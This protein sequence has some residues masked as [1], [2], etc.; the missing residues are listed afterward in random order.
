VD[1]IEVIAGPGSSLYGANAY[2]GIAHVITRKP[3]SKEP[4]LTVVSNLLLSNHEAVAPEVMV[5]YQFSDGVSLQLAGRSYKTDGDRGLDRFDPGRFFQGNF[6]PDSVFT[7]EHGNIPNDRLPGGARKPLP[8]GFGNDIDNT[9]L[10]GRLY[11]NGFSA[12]FTFWDRDEGIGSEVVAYEYFA[13]TQEVDYKA[14]HRGYT[15]FANYTIDLTP[16]VTSTSRAYFRSDR[17]LP[18]TGFTYTYQYQSVSNGVDPAVP[19]KKKSYHG[20]GFVAGF[21]QQMNIDAGERHKLVVGLQL[22]QEIL[23]YNGISLGAEQDSRSTIIPFTWPSELPT[24]Q[25]VFF[26]QNAAFYVQDDIPLGAHVALS[27]GVRYDADDE[28]GHVTNPRFGL[29]RSPPEGIGFKLVYSQ[30][31]K[32]PTVFE[33]FDEFRGN[34]DLE[35]EQVVTVE[36]ELNYQSAGKAYLRAN[37]FFNHLK[38]LIQVA[39]HPDPTRFP[40]GPQSQ[41]LDFYQNTGSADIYGLTLSGDFQLGGNTFG[42]ANYSYTRGDDGELDNIAAHKANVGINVLISDRLNVNVRVNWRGKTKAPASNRYFYPKTA[43]SIASVGYDYVTEASP[44]GYIDGTTIVNLALTGRNL[45]RGV[46]L[47]P[48][49]VIRNLFGKDF[50]TIGRQSGSGTR[51]TDSLQ[52]LVRNPAGFIP[53]YHP[54]PGR[55]IFFIARFGLTP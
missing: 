21:E 41:F 30:A 54:Q 37:L 4:G 15:G 29:V 12:G 51:P 7:S 23:Q 43:E 8:D 22:E 10:R 28:Y 13:N 38:D 34:V 2:A 3:S 52:P 25:P 20:V 11:M 36:G 9:F 27:G 31:F 14:H 18:E 39:P 46:D 55:E 48:Q 1:R 5:S 16:R 49:L 6:E 44:D 42:Y 40:I 19:D 35:P 33:Q 53:P 24:V 50:A 47:E 45:L 17:I 26:S 32:S